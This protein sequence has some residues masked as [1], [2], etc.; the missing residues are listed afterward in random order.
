M[1]SIPQKDEIAAKRIGIVTYIEPKVASELTVP[2]LD[3]IN[4][5]PV[6]K[7]LFERLQRGMQNE[8]FQYFIAHHND[9]INERLNKIFQGA[10]IELFKS[11]GHNIL[12]VL[13]GFCEKY[14]GLETI[15]IFPEQSIFPDCAL[16]QKM[17]AVHLDRKADVTVALEYP[18]GLLPQIIQ[19]ATVL[20][21]SK[22]K[23]PAHTYPEFFATLQFYTR[24]QNEIYGQPIKVTS[25]NSFLS[26]EP[27]L[28]RLP[29]KLVIDNKHASVAAE[30]VMN[31]LSLNLSCG[32]EA[33]YLFKEEITAIER[34]AEMEAHISAHA[35]RVCLTSA[36]RI[37][38]S[39]L[40]KYFSGGEESLF[41]LISNLDQ[42]KY[43]PIAV[44]PEQTVLAQKLAAL[45]IPVEIA[46]YNYT[47]IS[48]HNLLYCNRLLSAYNIGLVHMD[49]LPNQSL[50]VEAY[51]RQIP[52]IGHLRFLVGQQMSTSWN[53]CTKVIAISDAVAANLG[54]SQIDPQKI[55]RIYDGVDLTTFDPSAFDKLRLRKDAGLD[56]DSF[57]ISM[58]ARI[59]PEKRHEILIRA[60]PK[61]ID[62]INAFVIFIGEAYSGDTYYMRELHELIAQLN[63][64]RHVSF[65]GFKKDISSVYAMSDALVLCTLKEPFGRCII[66]A[67]AMG[68]PVIV[69]NAA[70]PAEI[71]RHHH[72]GILYDSTNSESLAD[73]V[74]H[75]C[76]DQNL[77]SKII[78]N[79][80]I[81]ASSFDVALHVE[82]VQ[83]LYEDI[84]SSQE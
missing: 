48:P 49:C 38:F 17:L 47:E 16:T 54:R 39:N 29:F 69:P 57:I 24:T 59:S 5:L 21:L 75:L 46:G 83:R 14:P 80:R 13:R 35:S 76:S 55:I 79:A 25:F 70:G 27:I 58:V 9:A 42:E 33:A 40:Q 62:N 18:L 22:F 50:M 7:H 37:L 8:F 34:E 81:R 53:L 84:L 31:R 12:S 36:T 67:L 3:N 56:P 32:F 26:P 52:I 1:I 73:A 64:D 11:D 10:E 19:T 61:I 60:L 66:E 78:A 44:F 51:Y 82:Q 23:I 43:Q 20:R 65:W 41:L 74:T 4:G 45:G 68:L 6:I 77:H 63:L 72:D 28:E 2:C 71:V 30:R 15:L